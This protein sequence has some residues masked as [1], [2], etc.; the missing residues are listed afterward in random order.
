MSAVTRIATSLAILVILTLA[1]FPSHVGAQTV[2]QRAISVPIKVV[3]VGLDQVDTSYLSWVKESSGNL[4][5]QFTNQVLL[6]NGTGEIFYPQYTVAKAPAEFK[7]EL[8]A[9]LTSIEKDVQNPDPWFGRYVTDTTNSAYCVW[10]NVTMKYA[11]YD[12]DSVEGWLF[13]HNQDL[14]GFSTNGWTIVVSYLPE[15]PSITWKDLQNFQLRKYSNENFMTP[16]ASTPHYYGV[17]AT[18]HDLGYQFRYRDFMNAW[19]GKQGR[20]WFVD[21]SAG[22][23]GHPPDSEWEDLPLQVAM[24]TNNITLSSTFGQQW[25]AEYVSQY[26]SQATMNLITP[27]FV[28]YPYYRPNY[29]IDVYVLDD[30]NTAEK[31]EI[32]IQTTISKAPIQTAFQQLVPYSSVTVNVNFVDISPELD[33]T[34]RSAYKYSDSWILGNEFCTPER[35]GLVDVTPVYKYIT[36]HMTDYE[37]NPFLSQDK[38]TIPAFAFAFSNQTY[39][40]EPMKWQMAKAYPEN[41]ALL[42]ISMDQAALISYNQYMFTLGNHVTPSQHGKG[43]GFTETVIHEVGHQFGLMHPHQFGNIGDFV[44]SPMGYFTNDYEFG[45][46]DR[47][48]VQRA[49][50]DQ[51]YFA[52]QQIMQQLSHDAASQIQTKLATVDS[53]YDAMNYVDAMHAALS[54]YQLAQ[55]LQGSSTSMQQTSTFVVPSATTP[56]TVEEPNMLYIVAGVAV[57]IVTGVGI[58]IGVVK[59]RKAG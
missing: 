56:T 3:L 19:G 27:D 40:T 54:A 55:Q 37:N 15:L 35:Y 17:S 53:S 48:A 43:V 32:P 25:L 16:P 8:E 59:K 18:D 30:R 28:Y 5:S 13:N 42:G 36:A 52:T 49:H 9:Y 21:L 26:V 38:M 50:V 34:I 57:G 47:D 10:Q 22:P 23:V 58:G 44:Y 20:M 2:G 11:V 14:G 29:Q 6:G 12:A 1:I 24:G 46:I 7:Q 4:P 51:V 31:S 39:F 33:Q 41:G 45:Q